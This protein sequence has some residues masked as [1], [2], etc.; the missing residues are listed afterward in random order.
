MTDISGEH[1]HGEP[2]SITPGMEKQIQEVRAHYEKC[3][4]RPFFSRAY[5]GMLG[6]YLRLLIQ[7]EA[8][9]FEVGCGSGDLLEQLPGRRLSG[10]D[11]SPA[12]LDRARLKLPDAK[13]WQGNGET[14]EMGEDY[15][16][17]LLSDLLNE[18]G[19]VQLLLENLRKGA[20]RDTRLVI[21]F[22]NTVWRP[23]LVLATA[24]GL[25][26]KRPRSNWLSRQDVANL[27]HVSGWEVVRQE[28]RILIPHPMLGIG[29]FINALLSPFLSWF[30]LVLFIVARPIK[31]V[32]IRREP[33]LAHEDGFAL[34]SVSV[35]VPARNEAGNIER[36]VERVPEMGS[37]T[38]IV[39]VEGNSSDQTW[40]KIREVIK[41]NP[42]KRIRAFQQAGKG[43]GDAMRT[44]YAN[45]MGDL[46]IILDADMTVPPEDL[47]KFYNALA[48]GKGEFINGV[49]L[50]YPLE[51]ESM[52]FL[53]MCGNK[54]FSLLF[55]WLL[56]QPIKD[57]LC[58]TKAFSRENYKRIE[59][60]RSYFGDFDPFG[61]F[62]LL[63]GAAHNSLRIVDIPV[64]YQSRTY[65]ETQINR[66]RDG[67]LLFRMAG[68]AARKI[69]FI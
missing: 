39:F 16:V 35:I 44:G 60:S 59:A 52:R 63:F 68:Y 1:S 38:E 19:D 48:E 42:D 15:D 25:R 66:W 67:I 33:L 4:E 49:R 37:W 53:N 41:E 12:Q 56:G 11:L 22:H 36:I 31:E 50:V 45:A 64:R 28:S 17:I 62:D 10:V 32:S 8:H 54:F 14:I 6:R 20:N 57:T 34:P 5:Q 13:L 23:V 58:G 43:K 2:R 69:K 3:R 21:N 24:L 47:P 61:D 65:G 46:F 55:S 26:P 51:N 18:A 29:T 9:V 30:C 27:L 7:E 40:E